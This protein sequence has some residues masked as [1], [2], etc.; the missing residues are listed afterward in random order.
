MKKVALLFAIIVALNALMLSSCKKD[1]K[2]ETLPENMEK[3]KVPANFNWKTT[4]DFQLTLTGKTAG[5]V[6]VASPQGI[7][8]QKAYLNANQ[9]YTMKLT[10]PT[11]EKSVRLKF[12]G[13][14]VLVTLGAASM[15]YQF[16]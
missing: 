14:D 2:P 5:I 1:P 13:Q 4:K 11:Y 8:Y 7:A 16:Q 6:E 12:L 9:P 3:L 15:S 10:V